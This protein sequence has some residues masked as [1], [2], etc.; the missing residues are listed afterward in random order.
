MPPAPARVNFTEDAL[1]DEEVIEPTTTTGTTIKPT[2]GAEEQWLAEGFA[3]DGDLNFEDLLQSWTP[4]E[5]LDIS[6]GADTTTAGVV[7]VTPTATTN[8]TLSEV[9][10][11][12]DLRQSARLSAQS[13]RHL[14]AHTQL[15]PCN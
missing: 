5:Q 4:A 15:K 1:F 7:A 13:S 9:T 14:Q 10:A 2:Q 6:D 11:F 8:I 12:R 3:F